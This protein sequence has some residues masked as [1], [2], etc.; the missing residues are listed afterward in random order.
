MHFV[1]MKKNKKFWEELIAYFTFTIIYI[2]DMTS[3]KSFN[4]YAQ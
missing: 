2:L 3:R 4:I 1:N